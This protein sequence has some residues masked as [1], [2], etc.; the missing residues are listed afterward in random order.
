MTWAPGKERIRELIAAGELEQVESSAEIANRLVRDAEQH[1]ASARAIAS[2][3][4]L[5]GAYQLAYDAL[6]KSAAALLATQG[7]PRDQS[8]WPHRSA[9]RGHRTVR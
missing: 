7:P 6:R 8:R 4:D 2:A 5:T 3:S 9:G 1:V